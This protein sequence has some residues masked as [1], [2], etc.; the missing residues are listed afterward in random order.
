MTIAALAKSLSVRPS[1]RRWADY[2]TNTTPAAQFDAIQK[3]SGGR[4]PPPQ[5]FCF[6]GRHLLCAKLR[7]SDIDAGAVEAAGRIVAQICKRWPNVRI[8][9]RADSG[10]AR[11]P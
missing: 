6:C 11:T 5:V 8:I 10:F 2:P 1:L 4:S 7:P 9:L 3:N